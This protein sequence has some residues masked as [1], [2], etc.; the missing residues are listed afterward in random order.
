MATT[1][2]AMTELD[3][4]LLFGLENVRYLGLGRLDDTTR[5]AFRR[6]LLDRLGHYG[7]QRYGTTESFTALLLVDEALHSVLHLPQSAPGS[8]WSRL[9]DGSRALVFAA[10]RD[11]PGV[12]V[13]LLARHY[14]ET[15]ALTSGN[16]IR[17]PLDRSGA[18]LACLRLWARV[19]GKDLP[20]RV[21]YSG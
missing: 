1:V 10:Q 9:Q 21:V 15:K 8:W 19:D 14:R 4:D 12:D 20:G 11:H 7:D 6:D 18:V 5:A 13:Q 3:V 16:D 2:L 17:H